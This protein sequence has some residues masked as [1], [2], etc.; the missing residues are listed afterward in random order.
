MSDMVICRTCEEPFLLQ[1]GKRG[2]RDECPRCMEERFLEAA[3]PQKSRLETALAASGG[4]QAKAKELVD[5]FRSEMRRTL[6]KLGC[7][8]EEA[9][10]I[11]EGHLNRRMGLREAAPGD[12]EH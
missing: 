12:D 5:R 2:Y 4:S 9:E 7:S 10:Q 6:H 8:Y 1:P 3:Q 11:I